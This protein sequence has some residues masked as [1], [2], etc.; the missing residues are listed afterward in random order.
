MP[1]GNVPP[2]P[3]RRPRAAPGEVCLKREKRQ[4]TPLEKE[5]DTRACL[6]E[7]HS[8][9]LMRENMRATVKSREYGVKSSQ[10]QSPPSTIARRELGASIC[11]CPRR[12]IL[13][14]KPASGDIKSPLQV[15]RER[16][17]D[18]PLWPRS[19]RPGSE[20]VRQA[21]RVPEKHPG[22]LNRIPQNRP[23]CLKRIPQT[24]PGSKN[25]TIHVYLKLLAAC[26]RSAYFADFFCLEK[27]SVRKDWRGVCRLRMLPASYCW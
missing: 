2:R 24:R 3:L 6:I 8:K 12:G 15:H 25:R 26:A 27:E 7:A 21:A 18:S 14:P 13:L 22:C 5:I 17:S 4:K 1:N 20:K 23:G 9:G 11:A 10:S 16:G 19:P